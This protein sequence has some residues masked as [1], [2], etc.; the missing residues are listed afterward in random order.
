MNFFIRE[1]IQYLRMTLEIDRERFLIDGAHPTTQFNEIYKHR[2][3]QLE[4]YILPTLPPPQCKHINELIPD[5]DCSIIG[6]IYKELATRKDV[7]K[8]YTE[9]GLD[10][11]VEELA[12]SEQDT[13]YVEDTTGRLLLEDIDPQTFPTGVIVGLFGHS[14]VAKFHVVSIHHP[15]IPP[16]RPLPEITNPPNTILFVSDL[17]CD[18]KENSK[19]LLQ[20]AKDCVKYPLLVLLGNNFQEP[21]QTQ[22]DDSYSFRKKLSSIPNMP[23][24]KLNGFL[25]TSR[26]KSN[27]KTILMPGSNDPCTIRL[28]QLPY[29]RCLV[30]QENVELVTNPASFTYQGV[31]FLCGS[32][33]SP[34]DVSKTTNLSFHDAQKAL[35]HWGHY[36]PTA[37]DHLPCVPLEQK[38]LMVIEE[39]PNVFVC[40]LADEFQVSQVKETIVVSVPSFIKTKSAVLFNMETREFT[41]QQYQ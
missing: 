36:A 2:L 21:Q 14:E 13:I 7:L 33:E 23:I 35:L 15:D 40:G 22:S 25:N 6:V 39:M 28:P 30:N 12:S 27:G 31:N 24:T 19:S 37:P 5:H 11:Q 38:D 4:P 1:P 9:I 20:L 16:S 26:N 18:S 8:E 17:S 34:V 41:L 10:S 3:I 29:H 32:G